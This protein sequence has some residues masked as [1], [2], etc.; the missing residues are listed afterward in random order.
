[1][2]ADAAR[3]VVPGR[4]DATSPVVQQ[5]MDAVD[6]AGYGRT[7][8]FAVRLALEEAIANALRHGNGMDP[9]KSIV[10]EFHV[11]PDGVA[12]DIEDSGHGFDVDAVPD[13]TLDENIDRPSG[14]G[15]MLMRAYMTTVE[16][17][18]VGNRVAMRYRRHPD[19]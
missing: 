2:P 15:I 10:I 12:I 17:N 5:I 7:S 1:M 3:L 8:R 16:F 19:E 13:P 18:E 11:G 6:R 4:R 9:A 14:R